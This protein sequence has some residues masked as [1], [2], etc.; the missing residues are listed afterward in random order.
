MGGVETLGSMP[1]R[2]LQVLG[3][4][5]GLCGEKLISNIFAMNPFI[6]LCLVNKTNNSCF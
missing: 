2:Q 5:S 6:K 3:T 1:L 4:E